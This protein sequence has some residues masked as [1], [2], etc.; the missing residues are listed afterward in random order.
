MPPA[1]VV[2]ARHAVPLFSASR[3]GPATSRRPKKFPVVPCFRVPEPPMPAAQQRINRTYILAVAAL[4]FFA[5]LAALVARAL[6]AS[7]LPK[8]EMTP[9]LLSAQDAPIP[10]NG[11]DSSTHLVYEILLTNFSSGDVTLEKVVVLGDGAELQTLEAA[12]IATRLQSVGTR[13]A[14]GTMAKSTQ[15]LF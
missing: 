15:A 2:G 7:T 8:E 9:L 6:G 3:S 13:E 12:E 14:V 11:S 1:T 4:V 10:F 5:I